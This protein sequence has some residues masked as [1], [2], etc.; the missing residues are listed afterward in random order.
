MVKETWTD[1]DI[2]VFTIVFLS[3]GGGCGSTTDNKLI[4]MK[5]LADQAGGKYYCGTD[6][7]A[8]DNAYAEIPGV[9]RSLGRC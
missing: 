2:R 6:K 4:D 9:L 1:N 5:A 8:I 7:E 3:S